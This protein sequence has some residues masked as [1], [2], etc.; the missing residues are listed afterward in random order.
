MSK[1]Q[2]KFCIDFVLSRIFE[3]VRPEGSYDD[4]IL[5]YEEYL[6]VFQKNMSYH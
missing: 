4:I 6:A 5:F 2:E 3:N 1:K